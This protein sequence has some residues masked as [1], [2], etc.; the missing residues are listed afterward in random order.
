M[1]NYNDNINDQK[2]YA[3]M[4]SGNM[5]YFGG[6]MSTQGSNVGCFCSNQSSQMLTGVTCPYLSMKICPMRPNANSPLTSENMPSIFAK[7]TYVKVKSVPI[8]Q[9][10]D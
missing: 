7:S 6:G 10:I 4:Q 2:N 5:S 3:N 8:S 1:D 9:L